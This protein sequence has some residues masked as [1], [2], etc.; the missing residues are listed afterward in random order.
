MSNMQAIQE[1]TKACLSRAE[2]MYDIDLS[3]VK[4]TFDL[5]GAAM[6]QARWR[7]NRLTR[8]ASDLQ[9]RF[10]LRMCSEDMNDAIN[11]TVP[12]EVAHI[13]NAVK[14]S[15]GANHNPGWRNV[16][17]ALGGT[18]KTYHDQEVIYAKGRTYA[19]TAS[20][21]QVVNVSEQRH[22]KIQR[23]AVLS[24]K[25]GGKINKACEYKL[26]GISGRRVGSAPTQKAGVDVPRQAAA[27]KKP[28][29]PA[30]T[31]PAKPRSKMTKAELIRD[32]IQR[33][34]R[35]D[36]ERSVAVAF[37]VDE[38]GMDPALARKYVKNNWD[39]VEA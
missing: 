13:V 5:K 10:N 38:L 18:G 26:V 15:T 2:Q 20:C 11:D 39:K 32:A 6:G 36:L 12:H 1:A 8:E 25:R 19:Y 7:I 31:K 21:G 16:C 23:G 22:R 14:P 29:T 35:M 28:T 27:A 3:R 24:L 4:I 9:L 17:L 33:C 30:A 37:G 34:K